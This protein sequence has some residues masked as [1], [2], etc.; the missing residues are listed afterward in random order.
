MESTLH[1]LWKE[2]A[3]GCGDTVKVEVT[4]DKGRTDCVNESTG[5][6]AEVQFSRSRIPHD[7]AKLS[8]AKSSGICESPK[9]IVR[10]PD[11]DY[12]QRLAVGKG[13]EVDTA[14]TKNL[15][16]AYVSCL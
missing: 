1:K 5:V 9:L 4:H 11:Y 16:K 2:V 6:C 10:E 13:I 3:C 14:T 8:W 15:L 12:A 7:I